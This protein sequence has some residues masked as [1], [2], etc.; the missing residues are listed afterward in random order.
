MT[1][2]PHEYSRRAAAFRLLS[3]LGHEMDQHRFQQTLDEVMTH[4]HL[5][6]VVAYLNGLAFERFREAAN[7]DWAAAT[8]AI[9]V[10]L[11]LAEDL[12]GLG[13]TE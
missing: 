5:R 4:P 3:A 6:D 7:G 8:A 12:D 13:E 2:L 1:E 10:N 11:R 9:D